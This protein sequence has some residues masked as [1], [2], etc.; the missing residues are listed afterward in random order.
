M[1]CIL[2]C[3][4]PAGTDPRL[5]P[6]PR[7]AS[8]SNVEV[9]VGLPLFPPVVV[10]AAMAM[11]QNAS[12]VAPVALSFG[13]E[14]NRRRLHFDPSES[15]EWGS[16]GIASP[17]HCLALHS[18][19]LAN[20]SVEVSA[21]AV[22]RSEFVVGADRDVRVS[23]ARPILEVDDEFG[24]PIVA[25]RGDASGYH[26]QGLDKLSHCLASLLV[27]ILSVSPY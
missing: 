8:V 4:R 22:R 25:D 17:A 19:K 1:A 3:K 2:V 21:D 15:R 9:G 26:R 24:L 5:G 10:L 12:L 27:V 20:E 23:V 18:T 11:G 16:G 14:P 13:T 6:S 7:L